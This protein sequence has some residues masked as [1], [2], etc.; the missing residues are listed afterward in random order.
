MQS[1]WVLQLA[2]KVKV[3]LTSGYNKQSDENQVTNYDEIPV[4]NKP[5][6]KSQL[7]L[8]IRAVLDS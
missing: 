1:Q 6:T 4:L 3:F 7:V 8:E 2:P 5:Y